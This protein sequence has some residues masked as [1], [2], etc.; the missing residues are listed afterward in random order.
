MLSYLRRQRGTYAVEFAIVFPLLLTFL[1][2]IVEIA[3]IMYI[4]N[5]L[6]DATRRGAF[7]ATVT[8]YRQQQAMQLV[9]Q[10]A[11]FRETPGE[12]VLGS[13]ITDDHIRIDYLALIRNSDNSL[14]MTPI[15]PENMPSCPARNRV[16]CTANPNDASCIRFVRV[17][18]CDPVDTAECQPVYYAPLFGLFPKTA[19]LPTSTTIVPAATL[20]YISGQTPCP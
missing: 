19:T 16:T 13:P 2:G 3:R 17:R 14:S 6:Q 12:L 7:G 18:V 8:D 1:L 15:G 5:T 10:Q 9:R 20:G 4:F 11:I